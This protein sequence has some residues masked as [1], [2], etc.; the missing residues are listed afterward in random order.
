MQNWLQSIFQ[1]VK[2]GDIIVA[3]LFGALGFVS[4]TVIDFL[5]NRIEKRQE[6]STELQKQRSAII[7]NEFL[8]T[9]QAFLNTRE[10]IGR[11]FNQIAHMR[12]ILHDRRMREYD[13]ESYVER[14]FAYNMMRLIASLEIVN[15]TGLHIVVSDDIA[16]KLSILRQQLR[17]ILS[18]QGLFREYQT[19]LARIVSSQEDSFEVL[20]DK[21]N[22]KIPGEVMQSLRKW[23]VK[24]VDEFED[25]FLDS[26]YQKNHRPG[27]S[28]KEQGIE[29]PYQ[30]DYNYG[31]VSNL[32]LTGSEAELMKTISLIFELVEQ[33][34]KL[35]VAGYRQK[36]QYLIGKAG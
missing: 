11:L 17:Q 28:L 5:K 3:V 33:Q 24:L 10:A 27:K 12:N 35:M 2:W 14:A 26:F 22:E 25:A 4:K 6:I 32:K 23:I 16:S 18:D 21:K 19:Q 36:S 29:V 30:F 15:S 20:F 34:Y 9:I 31:Q 13:R 8:I 1:N 7:Q